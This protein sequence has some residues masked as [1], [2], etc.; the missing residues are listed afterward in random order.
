MLRQTLHRT[1]RRLA[2]ISLGLCLLAAPRLQAQSPGY[3]YAAYTTS[4]NALAD[5]VT[6]FPSLTKRIQTPRLTT[7]IF[8]APEHGAVELT[9]GGTYLIS[10]GNVIG[11]VYYRSSQ[12]QSTRLRT[13][14]Q[15]ASVQEISRVWLYG[16]Q[17]RASTELTQLDIMDLSGRKL[18]SARG[19]REVPLQ[20]PAGV[21]L[22]RAIFPTQTLVCRLTVR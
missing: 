22:L 3:Q 4:Y 11:G 14:D 19:S 1:R 20:L 15:A 13:T 9:N 8:A 17:L 12:A 6:R 18:L 5:T 7:R 21:Y 16:K 2:L 10:G